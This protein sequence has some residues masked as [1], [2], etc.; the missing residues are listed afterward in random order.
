[1]F[2]HDIRVYGKVLAAQRRSDFWAAP[3][4]ASWHGIASD[5]L[6]S[7]VAGSFR[8]QTCNLQLEAFNS[9]HALTFISYSCFVVLPGI[10][11]GY[12]PSLSA[13]TG[14][15]ESFV[16]LSSQPRIRGRR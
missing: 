13:T 10:G 8:Q 16:H 11:T 5:K 2:A 3:I 4:P 15:G 9:A 14:G 6:K 12:L 1:M 7:K